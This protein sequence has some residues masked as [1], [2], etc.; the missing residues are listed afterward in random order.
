MKKYLKKIIDTVKTEEI[1][2]VYEYWKNAVIKGDLESL[3]K[4]CAENFAWTNDMGITNDKTESLYKIAS[5]NLKYL[6]WI[7]EYT[8]VK[9]VGDI[10]ILKTREIL[11]LIVYR[12]RVNAVHDVTAIFINQDGKWLLAGGQET[13]SSLN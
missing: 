2:Q 6:S 1:K 4:V 3:D 8:A 10:A 5:D 9:M 12:Q 13:S 7:S 11:K